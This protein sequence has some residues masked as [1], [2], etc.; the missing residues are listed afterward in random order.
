[1]TNSLWVILHIL[2][3]A[4]SSHLFLWVTGGEWHGTFCESQSHRIICNDEQLVSDIQCTFHER[5]SYHIFSYDQQGVSDIAHFVKGS[6][7]RSFPMTNSLWVIL[8]ILWKAVSS[9]FFLWPT[10]SEWNGTFYERLPH[11]NVSYDQQDVSDIAHFVKGSLITSFPM[12]NSQW[13]S[14]HILWKSSHHTF[15]YDQ[16]RVS[17]KLHICESQSYHIFPMTNRKWVI[18]HICA[19]QSHQAFSYD[20]QLVSVRYSMNWRQSHHIFSFDQQLVSDFANLL[21]AYLNL[22]MFDI[23]LHHIYISESEHVAISSPCLPCNIFLDSRWVVMLHEIFSILY[24]TRMNFSPCLET[25]CKGALQSRYF[26]PFFWVVHNW[27]HCNKP[28]DCQVL[29]CKLLLFIP[30]FML[31]LWSHYYHCQAILLDQ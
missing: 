18:L 30:W 5:Q 21:T 12:T 10:A 29:L 13:V 8:H 19:R 1:M 16:Q 28:I 17:D 6:L 14:L 2:W 24:I 23:S 11:H 26:W 31:N 9:H 15:S 27:C 22:W 3:K 20:Q 7:I 25:S 4:I